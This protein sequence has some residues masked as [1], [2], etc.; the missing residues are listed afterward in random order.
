M[1]EHDPLYARPSLALVE[2]FGAQI[3]LWWLPFHIKESRP[4]GDGVRWR[5]LYCRAVD[6][7]EFAIF[8]DFAS[9][10]YVIDI[11]R[12]PLSPIRQN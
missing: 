11:F 12:H 2:V 4:V 6:E 10:I 8:T 5:M 1:K 3:L 9:K 7:D